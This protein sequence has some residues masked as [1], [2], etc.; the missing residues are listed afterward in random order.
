MNATLALLELNG[1]V[2]SVPLFQKQDRPEHRVAARSDE[3]ETAI[4]TRALRS[5]GEICKTPDEVAHAKRFMDTVV[6]KHPLPRARGS[7]EVAHK[8]PSKTHKT[9]KDQF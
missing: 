2:G 5:Y 1:T 7:S 6:P 9:H 8:S 3:P 4:R